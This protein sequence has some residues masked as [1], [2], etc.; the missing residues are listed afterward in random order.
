MVCL[1]NGFKWQSGEFLTFLFDKTGNG[2]TEL[3]C[4]DRW[5]SQAQRQPTRAMWASHSLLHGSQMSAPSAG[6]G[7]GGAEPVRGQDDRKRE[8]QARDGVSRPA[9]E[10]SPAGR[11]FPGSWHPAKPRDCK[12]A[13]HRPFTRPRQAAGWQIAPADTGRNGPRR[14]ATRYLLGFA[15][16]QRQPTKA[17]WASYCLWHGSQVSAPSGGPGGGESGI[18]ARSGGPQKGAPR[19]E[20]RVATGR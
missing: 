10:E 8:R 11:G 18:G 13:G 7:G 16:A 9:G 12:G 20:W 4:G 17:M 3:R 6:P 19:Q 15:G 1:K 2:R 14:I 5:A